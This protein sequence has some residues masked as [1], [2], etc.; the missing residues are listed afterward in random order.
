MTAKSDGSGKGPQGPAGEAGGPKRPSAIIDLKATEVPAKDTAARPAAGGSATAAGMPTDTAKT[1]AARAEAPAAG[2]SDAP[3]IDTS[4]PETSKAAAAAAPP[5]SAEKPQLTAASQPPASRPGPSFAGFATHMAAGI[6]GGFLALLGADLIG[7][8]LGFAGMPL[9]SAN[10]ELQRRVE[11]LEQT[12]DRSAVPADLAQKV[13]AAEKRAARIDDVTKGLAD[14]QAAQA[15]LAT[16]AKALEARLAQPGGTAETRL[17]K[18]EQTLSTLAAAAGNDPQQRIPQLAALSG[19]VSDLE[20][21]LNNQLAEVRRGVSQD[22][23]TRAGQAVEASEA[24]RSGT[25]RLDRELSAVKTEAARTAQRLETFKA[26]DDRLEQ[27]IRA[28][29]EE[30]GSTKS[31]L[32]GLRNDVLAQLK[33]V[34]R[35]QDVSTAIA[36]LGT[37]IAT[38]EQGLAGVVKSEQDRKTNAERIVLSLELANLRRALDRGGSYAAELAEVKKVAGSAVDLSVLDRYREQGVPTIVE[39]SRE[40]RGVANA[41]L[42]AES[43]QPDA[44]VVDRLLSGAKSI[45]RVRKTSAS[46]DDKSA[47]GVL[48]RMESALKQGKLTD[49]VAESKALPP[50]AQ[51]SAQPWLAKIDARAAVDRAIARIEDELKVSL[52]GKP[53]PDK[54][55]EKRTQ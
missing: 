47:E 53:Q 54:Q 40:F 29:Q 35:P 15:K 8:Q 30:A 10:S 41:A 49:V 26:T 48:A 3:R 28:A 55:P 2:K 9:G 11:M 51:T 24:A 12:R 32:D 39:L 42:D 44:S 5:R 19:K 36:P 25:Q 20:Q 18:L 31:A 7:Q 14:L 22:I 6:A 23:E 17:A 21:A 46:T 4:K 43:E 16:D 33:T 34:A 50:K 52:G 27:A 45:V 13:T 38:L 1:M 37:K